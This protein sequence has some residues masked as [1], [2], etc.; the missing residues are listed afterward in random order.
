MFIFFIEFYILQYLV[1]VEHCQ[2]QT[3]PEDPYHDLLFIQYFHQCVS[4]Y[5][6]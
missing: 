1:H 6:S 3:I 5:Y 4:N 2:K